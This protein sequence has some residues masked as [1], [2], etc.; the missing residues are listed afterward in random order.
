MERH[1]GVRDTPHTCGP[2]VSGTLA[3]LHSDIPIP[4]RSCW[5][6]LGRSLRFGCYPGR[7]VTLVWS[8]AKAEQAWG[9]HGWGARGAKTFHL[10]SPALSPATS[11]LVKV[12][13]TCSC[14]SSV[15]SA[16]DGNDTLHAP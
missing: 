9:A 2:E 8:E 12:A 10:L 3:T 16:H 5:S 6:V 11:S 4:Q 1:R 14:R 7:K 13:S 15:S